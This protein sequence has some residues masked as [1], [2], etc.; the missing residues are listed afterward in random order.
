[1]EVR[2]FVR[3]QRVICDYL[4]PAKAEL[5][6]KQALFS[7]PCRTPAA[8]YNYRFVMLSALFF[9]SFSVF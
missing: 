7:F 8:V 2:S 3:I 5:M 4:L 1:M 6:Q 9:L